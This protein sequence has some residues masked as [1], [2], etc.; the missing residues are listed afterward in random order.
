[1]IV[2]M[3]EQVNEMERRRTDLITLLNKHG[4]P[5]EK[6][7][8]GSA[9]ALDHLLS[10]VLGGE[11]ILEETGNGELVR[12]V[13]VVGVDVRYISTDGA[14]YQLVEDRQEFADGRVRRRMLASSL[15]E[16]MKPGEE[17]TES[18]QRAVEEELR[19]SGKTTMERLGTNRTAQVS[20]S[21]PGLKA[22]FVLHTF[23][24]Y[25]KPEQYQPQGYQE[26]QPDK[27]TYF[28]WKPIAKAPTAV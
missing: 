12:K 13:E 27:T 26:I 16:K 18:A 10:E 15:T 1:M 2:C 25:L 22:Q 21:Y 20:P 9:K 17:P 3:T 14:E 28:A 23:R 8:T 19:V 5:Y 11:T 7:G 4:V 24:T 6:W